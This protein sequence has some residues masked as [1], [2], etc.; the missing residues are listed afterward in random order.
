MLLLSLSLK[1]YKN[2]DAQ[3]EKNHRLL[4]LSHEVILPAMAAEVTDN[5]QRAQ[6]E[7]GWNGQVVVGEW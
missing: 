1:L 6:R 5:V 4:V 2:E 7:T 3:I